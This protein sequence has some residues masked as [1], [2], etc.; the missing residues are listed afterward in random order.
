[1]Q[2]KTDIGTKMNTAE[3][4]EHIRQVVPNF[5]DPVIIESGTAYHYTSNWDLVYSSRR[6]LGAPIDENL[7]QTQS[8]LKSPPAT[9]DPG[10]VFCYEEYKDAKEEGIGAQI[11]EIQFESAIKAMHGQESDLGDLTNGMLTEL[12]V[13]DELNYTPHTLLILTTDI[14]NFQLVEQQ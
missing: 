4:L 3:L 14:K 7:D 11:V 8:S 2:K 6:F 13:T 10:V 9:N 1:M 12:G 5:I